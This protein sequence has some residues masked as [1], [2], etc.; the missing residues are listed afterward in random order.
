ML[1]IRPSGRWLEMVSGS[2]KPKF[3][4]IFAQLHLK[5]NEEDKAFPYIERLAT[6]HPEMAKDLVDECQELELFPGGYLL[7]FSQ[8][9]GDNLANETTDIVPQLAFFQ[10]LEAET[11]A[12]T[13][14]DLLMDRLFSGR[15]GEKIC[16]RES[17]G[18]R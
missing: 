4:M 17:R 10:F 2:L 15:H 3:D 8:L 12:G 7:L 5:V 13:R 6:T 1:E 16:G 14:M 18:A 9:R 11:A